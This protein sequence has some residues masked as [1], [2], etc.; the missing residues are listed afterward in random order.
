MKQNQ[1]IVKAL[2]ALVIAFGVQTNANAQF[3][4]LLKK[5]K[6]KVENKVNETKSSTVNQVTN[7]ASETAGVSTNTSNSNAKWRWEVKSLPFYNNVHW[8][9]SKSEEY[10][11]QWGH[12]LLFY[13]DVFCNPKFFGTTSVASTLWIDIDPAKKIAVPY[14]EPYRYAV[15]KQMFDD[16]Q[17]TSF[18][19]L[20]QLLP[21]QNVNFYSR[22]H[23][24]YEAGDGI[25]NKAEGWLSPYGDDNK[26]RAERNQREEAAFEFAINKFP[27]EQFCN[28]GI[29]LIQN[30]A[31]EYNSGADIKITTMMNLYI[32]EPLYEDIIKRHPKFSEDADCVRQFKLAMA[33]NPLRGNNLNEGLLWDALDIY[34]ICNMTPQPMPETVNADS[35]TKGKAIEAGKNYAGNDFVDVLIIKS[36]WMEQENP[37]KLAQKKGYSMPVVL[38][39]K[40]R[41]H[42]VM[43]DMFLRRDS[44]DSNKFELQLAPGVNKPMP[45]DY[46]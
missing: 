35:F 44:R 7:T 15:A 30:A 12:L 6:Q 18:L 21:F 28:Y 31:K 25:V 5:A 3:G 4:G 17:F 11:Y 42:Y 27:L 9:G 37:Q 19:F 36:D 22:F 33:Q 24:G 38:V 10:K 14:D 8:N 1:T 45:I 20:A 43:R 39:Y 23:Y 46:K 29:S 2:T 41:G 16:P 13:K 32:I 34:R 40:V 26:M